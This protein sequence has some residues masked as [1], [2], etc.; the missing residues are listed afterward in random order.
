MGITN[1]QYDAVMRVYEKRQIDNHHVEEARRKE[2]YRAIS[3]LGELDV[4]VASLSVETLR[5]SLAGKASGSSEETLAGNSSRAED[6][7][8]P[9]DED[10]LSALHGRII[11]A[12]GG[13]DPER[14]RRQLLKEHGFPEDYLDPVYT[15]PDCRDTGWIGR[16]H[17]HCFERELISLFYTQSNLARILR[18]EN[19][20]TFDLNCYRTDL[21]DEKSGK[22]SREIMTAALNTCRRFAR[23]YGSPEQKRYLMLTG[24]TGLGKT[25]LTHCIA[26]A[27]IDKGY[28][29]IYYSAGELFDQL[30]KDRF[31]RVKEEEREEYGQD[32]LSVCDLLII[33]DLGTELTNSFVGT[34]F[35]QLLN[36]RIMRG[37][38]IVLSTNLSAQEIGRTYS[39]RIS[40]RIMEH[41]I[42][43]RAYGEDIRIRKRLTP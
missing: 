21:I 11:E 38:G 2:A 42:L 30:A 16:K 17:C 18:E 43:I 24:Q 33:D 10:V 14:R 6:R 40:S 4:E 3:G 19:F 34:E 1:S 41:F 20:E 9:P 28:S 29:V 13:I 32:L 26:K 35:F 36:T 37:K 31:G 5:K 22:S 39:D 27:L 12:A 15:C 8:L 7:P 25:F 23:D